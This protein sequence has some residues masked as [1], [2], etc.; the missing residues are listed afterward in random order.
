MTTDVLILGAG[1]SG[2]TA[3]RTLAESGKAVKILDKG[4]GVGGRVA[5]RWKGTR[6]DIQGRWDHGAQFVTFRSEKLISK[7]KEW[8]AWSVLDE[9]IPSHSDTSLMRHRPLEGMNGFAKALA[10]PLDIERSQRIVT[11]NKTEDGWVACS[12][13][14]DTFE[15]KQVISTIPTPQVL[16]LIHASK[17]SLSDE[18]FQMLHLVTY[19]RCL[20][21]LAETAEPVTLD[22]NG[23]LRV[24]SGVL[25]SVISHQQKGI[26]SAPT[27]TANA[28]AAF[29]L[30]W[31]DRDRSTAASVLRAAL[32]EL[33][34][35][36]IVSVQLHGWKFSKASQRIPA[37]FVTLSNGCTLAGDAF[38]AGDDSVAPDLHPRI[39]SAML[40][41]L[42]AGASLL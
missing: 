22:H 9:W 28:T 21:L 40:S 6:D 10:A 17:W 30:E 23:Y 4:R 37:P 31:Y 33:L 27:F 1:I 14:G 18:E 35:S 42:H 8:D 15:A 7:L 41:G 36:S 38:Q 26:S 34:E 16:D 24:D 25:E 29:S 3:G 5:T 32:Q 12:E 11:L 39:E 13:S 20:S 2:L 19:D